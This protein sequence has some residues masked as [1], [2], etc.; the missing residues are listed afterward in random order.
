MSG[1]FSAENIG[2]GQPGHAPR[3]AEGH[4]PTHFA[5]D[6]HSNSE[7]DVILARYPEG[8]QA[9][10][11]IPLLYIVQNQMG[12]ETGSAWVPRVA[13]DAVA[14]RLSMPP[15]RVYEVATFY[16]MF[17]TKPIGRY[18][19]Q[20]CTN[21][22][23]WLRG[24]DDVVAACKTAGGVSGFGETSADGLFTMTEVECMGA[25]ANAPMMQ[26]N[27]DYYEDL[28]GDRTRDLID[29]LKRGEKPE[30]G[31]TIDRFNSA[32][33]G[34]RT[35]LLDDLGDRSADGQPGNMPETV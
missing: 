30:R 9:S 28:D 17:N 13:M 22:P 35:T 16:L 29:A 14:R 19:L 4:Q 1:H 31:P 7:I 11:V 24:S 10:G 23:C 6:E 20:V 21:T 18:H 34:G 2:H 3:K 33:F 15:I 5:F 25:C 27:D 26:V 8:R 12:R 32:A